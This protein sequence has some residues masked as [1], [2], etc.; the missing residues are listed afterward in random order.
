VAVAGYSRII[1]IVIYLTKRFGISKRV[2]KPVYQSVG[3]YLTVRVYQSVGI[4]QPL[5][6]SV[7]ICQSFR[8]YIAFRI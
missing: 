6:Q 3:I 7:R 4:S 5:Y 2:S 1:A 8:F